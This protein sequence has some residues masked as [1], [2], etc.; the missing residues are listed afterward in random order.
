MHTFAKEL[1][2]LHPDV[3]V[4]NSTPAAA[5]LLR[6]TR[7]IPIVCAAFKSV[8]VHSCAR[9]LGVPHRQALKQVERVPRLRIELNELTAAFC[10][11]LG[12]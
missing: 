10:R 3:L 6:E 9:D 5:A 1:V 8:A 11:L 12:H 7:S 4:G 2:A